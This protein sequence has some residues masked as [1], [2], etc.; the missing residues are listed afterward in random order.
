[1][2]QGG[3]GSASEQRKET[4]PWGYGDD[5]LKYYRYGF[6][7]GKQ[8]LKN[9]HEE[10]RE[11][12]SEYDIGAKVHLTQM[13]IPL[14]WV[15]ED[16]SPAC[17]KHPLKGHPHARAYIVGFVSATG[18]VSLD[19]PG[20]LWNDTQKKALEQA[21]T[22]AQEWTQIFDIL[23]WVEPDEQDGARQA[24]KTL[25]TAGKVPEGATRAQGVWSN[26]SSFWQ[27]DLKPLY[28]KNSQYFS[29]SLAGERKQHTFEQNSPPVRWADKVNQ[30]FLGRAAGG[31]AS[32]V[33]AIDKTTTC[34]K[35]GIH[36]DVQALYLP[37]ESQGIFH[38]QYFG[39]LAPVLGNRTVTFWLG[40]HL[41]T[42]VGA[43]L[44]CAGF[45]PTHA[46]TLALTQAGRY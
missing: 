41:L 44:C 33:V 26:G 35:Q 23:L 21:C 40:S 43:V 19:L 45:P 29:L 5:D 6:E 42:A 12:S 10:G 37:S 27:T 38:P 46:C 24:V 4:R 15:D 25:W 7:H 9:L 2:A 20:T 14:G 32:K 11:A 1:M 17:E 36:A 8:I 16:G 28:Q 31:D 18:C 3:P 13:L 39:I 22:D 30:E 34:V